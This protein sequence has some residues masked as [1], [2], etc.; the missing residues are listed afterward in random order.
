MMGA[1]VE[2]RIT[3]TQAGAT[4]TAMKLL[5]HRC[6]LRCSGAG[7]STAD[8]DFSNFGHNGVA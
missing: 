4:A 3:H 2:R 8:I 6:R 5:R 7:L 1:Y